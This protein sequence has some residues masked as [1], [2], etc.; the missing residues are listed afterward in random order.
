MDSH[1]FLPL[2][3]IN[4]A[5]VV[6]VHGTNPQHNL[7]LKINH[8]TIKFTHCFVRLA[9]KLGENWFRVI[10]ATQEDKGMS[11]DNWIISLI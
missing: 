6:T 1:L 2:V 10:Y 4:H 9:G 3:D 8:R 11:E 5:V 7:H